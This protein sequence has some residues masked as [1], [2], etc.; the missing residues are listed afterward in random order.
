MD[1][2]IKRDE[3]MKLLNTATMDIKNIDDQNK[4]ARNLIKEIQNI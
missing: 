2:E 1:D 4:I 3:F